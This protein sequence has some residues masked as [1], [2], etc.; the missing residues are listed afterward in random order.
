[1][2]VAIHMKSTESKGN[3]PEQLGDPRELLKETIILRDDNVN[4]I[5]E[6]LKRIQPRTIDI[7]R[8]FISPKCLVR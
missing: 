8:E 3:S 2:K 6:I 7:L 1:M 5:E 4:F